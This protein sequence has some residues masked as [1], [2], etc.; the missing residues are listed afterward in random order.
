MIAGWLIFGRLKLV[1]Y[2][3]AALV[4]YRSALTYEA[5]HGE[6][7]VNQGTRKASASFGDGG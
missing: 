3:P 1:N 4:I 5:I 7:L 2:R 6:N